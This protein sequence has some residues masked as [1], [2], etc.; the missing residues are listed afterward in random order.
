MTWD[1]PAGGIE[2]GVGEDNMARDVET[3]KD[4]GLRNLVCHVVTMVC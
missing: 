2:I 1:A 4:R 3:G